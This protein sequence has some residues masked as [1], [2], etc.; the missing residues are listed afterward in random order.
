MNL[1]YEE[2]N[3]LIKRCKKY[4][5]DKYENVKLNNF[6][7]K[8]SALIL[9]INSKDYTSNHLVAFTKQND[10]YIFQSKS[11]KDKRNH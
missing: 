4:I 5:E 11:N 10:D 7:Y 3:K 1:K 9:E 2:Y 8:K 6:D